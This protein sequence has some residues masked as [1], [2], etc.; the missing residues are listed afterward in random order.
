MTA[1]AHVVHHK[2]GADIKVVFVGPCIAKKEETFSAVPEDVDVA[3]S[4]EEAQRMMQARR[5]EEASLQPSEFDPPH[6]DL[7]ALFP[8][9][10]GL[11]QSARLTD[12]LIADDILVNN[13]R[14]GFVEAIKELSAGQCKPRL[15]EVLACQG[16]SWARVL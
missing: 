11:I 10:Q 13:G 8:I 12:D 2:L 15:L 9:S 6:G 3:I 4:F 7:G 16:A 14:R 5:I 1:T